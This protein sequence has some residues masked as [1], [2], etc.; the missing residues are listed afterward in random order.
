M[1]IV[2]WMLRFQRTRCGAFVEALGG[3]T[4]EC[5]QHSAVVVAGAEFRVNAEHSREGRR[6]EQPAP[7]V[8]DLVLQSCEALRVGLQLSSSTIERPFGIIRRVH[9]SST[10]YCPNET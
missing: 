3:V 6:R 10:R 5:R 8:V 2:R 4:R 7:M 1:V 9:T